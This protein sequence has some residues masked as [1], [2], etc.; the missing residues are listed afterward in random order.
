MSQGIQ[1]QQ[2]LGTDK[3]NPCFTICRDAE[4]GRLHV[5]Y[6]GDVFENVPDDRNDPQYK[7]MVARLY[8]AGVNA[9]KLKEAFGADR[10]TMK[11][12]RALLSI[13]QR[14]VLTFVLD[15]GIFGREFFQGILSDDLKRPGEDLIRLMFKRWLQENDFKYL[16]KH[17]GINQITSYASVS[18]KVLK[19]Q[20]EPVPKARVLENFEIPGS[21]AGQEYGLS[22]DFQVHWTFLMIFRRKWA[23]Q[24]C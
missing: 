10:E 23:H 3:R 21:Q 2:I 8:N 22:P 24:S 11:D 17:F 14:R 7:M 4:A 13:D 20:V 6:G 16:E 19:D 1:L 9:V 5:Y 18:Y 15:R 12:F